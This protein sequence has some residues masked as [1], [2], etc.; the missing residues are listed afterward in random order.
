MEKISN[1]NILVTGGAGFIGSHLCDQLIQL[2]NHVFCLDNLVGTQNSTRN[3]E[4]LLGNPLF[5]FINE[6]I[7]EWATP[8]NLENFEYIFHQ[9]ASKNTVSID[10]P[11]KDLDTNALGTL[12][13]L[14]AAKEIGIRKFVHGSTGSVY[15][16]SKTSLKE[17]NHKNPVSFYGVS[18]LAGE[19]YCQVVNDIYEL[20]FTVLRYFHVI[21]T[22]Q[23]EGEGGGVVPIFVKACIEN[24]PLTIFGSGDQIR[25][26]TSVH[27][28]VKANI[29]VASLGKKS[30]GIFNCASAI[31]VS[32]KELADFVMKEMG[33]DK[34]IN[35]KEKRPGDIF[36]FDINNESI[37][38][39][40]MSFSQDW[41]STVREVI[42]DM[43]QKHNG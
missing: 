23:Y 18:K 24:N 14:L 7:T 25:S 13:L 40:G 21:G 22:R 34:K 37:R 10:D 12:K 2:E 30:L 1:S 29:L 39:L 42:T 9:A 32:I 17:T 33:N 19:S 4:H 28:V 31:K 38:K 27:D 35:Y 5:T 16:E 36:N 15:G 43:S 41:K 8:K 3:I 26:F 11:T 20:D 6:S